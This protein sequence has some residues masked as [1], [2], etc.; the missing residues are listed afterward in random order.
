MAAVFVG[1][2]GGARP[3][4]MGDDHIRLKTAMTEISPYTLESL[5]KD[6]EFVLYRGQRETEPSHILVVAPLSKQPAQGTFRRLEHEY[7]LRT[8]LDPASAVVPL[9]LIRDNERTMLV[10]E[11]RL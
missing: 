9:A 7:A 1:D 11:D 4:G 8:R 3:R 5:R 6:A 10:L 2:K